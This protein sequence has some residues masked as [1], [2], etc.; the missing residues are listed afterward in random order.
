MIGGARAMAVLLARSRGERASARVASYKARAPRCA[1]EDTTENRMGIGSTIEWTEATWNP[2][3]GCTKISP[4]CAHCYA[5]RMS[6][7]L[8]AMGQ[9]NYRNGFE[10]T[11]QPHMLE[12][13]LR[14]RKP[15]FVFVNS[16]SDLFHCDVPVEYIQKVFDVMRR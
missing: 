6:K 10:L 13:P 4:G 12:V 15:Q 9:K 3:T 11:L 16:M 5:E 7:R 2:V 14:W 1:A 8:A